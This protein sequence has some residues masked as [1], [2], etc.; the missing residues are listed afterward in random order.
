[1]VH[2]TSCM[3]VESGGLPMHD[4]SGMVLM[5]LSAGCRSRAPELRP[6][7]VRRACLQRM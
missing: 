7:G 2:K 3:V 4:V 1:M 5:G 6:G